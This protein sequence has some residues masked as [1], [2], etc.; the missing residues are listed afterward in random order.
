[1]TATRRWFRLDI[2]WSASTWLAVLRPGGRLGWIELLG[3]VKGHGVA[4]RV[5]A[6]PPEIAAKRWGIPTRDVQAML[7]AAT[8]NGALR[9]ED[10][11][12][13]ITG[14]KKYQEVDNTAA[15]RMKRHREKKGARSGQT[16]PLRRNSRNVRRNPSRDSDVDVDPDVDVDRERTA[17]PSPPPPPEPREGGRSRSHGNPDP[18]VNG[19][20]AV[21]H[22]SR[23]ALVRAAEPVARLGL[24]RL[25]GRDDEGDVEVTPRGGRPQL[26]GYGL[27]LMAWRSWAT[28]ARTEDPEILARALWHVVDLVEDITPPMTMALVEKL[29]G[30]LEQAV[31][32]ALEEQP[33]TFDA[34][35]FVAAA[36]GRQEDP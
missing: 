24:N 3:Y 26:V 34:L 31:H 9:T 22:P 11:D 20:G 7:D 12:W 32:R 6:L 19:N 15:E 8:G 23:T 18:H 16:A 30:V 29:P 17:T 27:D 35:G 5:K 1:M 13:V 10:G 14:W 4:G 2:T 21:A 28:F 25:R 36:R 33:S